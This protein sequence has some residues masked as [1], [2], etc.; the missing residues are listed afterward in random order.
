MHYA[1]TVVG[2]VPSQLTMDLVERPEFSN[3]I[4]GRTPAENESGSF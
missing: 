2:D 1:S 4:Q 3:A